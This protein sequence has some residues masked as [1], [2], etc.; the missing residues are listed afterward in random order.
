M[1]ML[2]ADALVLASPVY[3]GSYCGLFKH[4]LDLL[5]PLVAGR[6]A[7]AARRH[8]RRAAA[9]AGDR[10][11][12]A[13]APRLLRGADAR[14]RHLRRRL[15][16]R[17]RR[18][19]PRPA[20]IER[21]DR[22]V[23]QFAPFLTQAAGIGGRRDAPVALRGLITEYASAGD[24]SCPKHRS[25]SPTGSRTSRAASSSATS[26]SAPAGT[27]TT[28]ASW[29]RSP[30]RAGFDYALS[31]IRFTAGYGADNQ[32]ESVAFS[33]A[34]AAATEK[35]TVIAA[36]LARAVEPGAGGEADRDDQPPDRR[37]H[38]GQRGQRLVPRRV[39][40]DRRALARP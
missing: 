39:R 36:L 12:A 20:A 11:P 7:G 23:G 38:R 1:R 32:H 18:R 19:R 15:G 30:R 21:L 4:L 3:K 10:A 28:T 34:L 27:S 16:L 40:G 31:Q 26:S 33:H 5:D 35:L 13:A 6:Q 29:R 22:A 9:C 2:S 8:R 37:A 24:H 25:S 14:D 17:R